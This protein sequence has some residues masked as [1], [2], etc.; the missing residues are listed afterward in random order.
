MWQGVCSLQE[1]VLQ[2]HT[3]EP[4]LVTS[5]P[6]S[7]GCAGLC[8]RSRGSAGTPPCGGAGGAPRAPLDARAGGPGSVLP[9]PAGTDPP[10]SPSGASSTQEPSTSRT[11]WSSTCLDLSTISLRPNT[12]ADFTC[13]D[14]LT[15]SISICA[16][17]CDRVDDGCLGGMDEQ[18]CAPDSH[19]ITWIGVV[20]SLLVFTILLMELVLHK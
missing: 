2:G 12:S 13:P 1:L 18:C 11:N 6:R 4:S 17:R 20:L 7:L 9:P 8:S 15:E 3:G 10:T 5:L 16:K 14:A 19:L